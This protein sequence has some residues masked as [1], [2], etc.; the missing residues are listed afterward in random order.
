MCLGKISQITN[1]YIVYL[2]LQ[3]LVLHLSGMHSI[4]T[5]VAEKK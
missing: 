4:G 5:K 1:K 2:V 3:S